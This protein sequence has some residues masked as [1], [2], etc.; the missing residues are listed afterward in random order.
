MLLKH[1][2]EKKAY[3]DENAENG[4]N[5]SQPAHLPFAGIPNRH[6]KPQKS[7]TCR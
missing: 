7:I 4:E 5:M 2:E 3:K 1:I 6:S